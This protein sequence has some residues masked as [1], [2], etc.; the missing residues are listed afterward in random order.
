VLIGGSAGFNVAA[1]GTGVLTYQWQKNGLAIPVG[2]N[3]GFT[4][5]PV[6]MSDLGVYAVAVSNAYGGVLSAQASL[7]L[8]TTPTIQS[9]PQS[10]TNNAGTTAIFSVSASGNGLIYRWQRTGTNISDGGNLFGSATDT[11]A[12]T[13]VTRFDAT[14]YTVVITNAAGSVTS[15][16]AL[17]TVIFAYPFT[18]PFNYPVGSVLSNQVSPDFMTWTDV[19]TS[20]AG[21]VVTNGAG[22]LDVPGLAPS[23]GNSIRFGGAG[24]S[25][26]LSFLTGHAA[27]TGTIYFSFALNVLDLT[28]AAATTGGFIAGF[29]NSIGTQ[30]NQPSVIAPR[31]YIRT[32]GAGFNF[33]VAKNADNTTTWDT[34][35]YTINQTNFIVG[36]YTFNT[37][38]DT[39]D[40][41]CKMWINPAPASFGAASPPIPTV[42]ALTGSD[43]T[44]NSIASFVFFQRA[45]TPEPAVMIADELRI[46]TAWAGVT[47][48]PA[49]TILTGPAS[50]TNNPGTTATFTVNAD[51]SNLGYQ[52]V[53]NGVTLTNGGNI[54]GAT[55]STLTV[56]SVSQSDAG[57]YQVIVST[58]GGSVVSAAATLTVT[59]PPLV[60][61]QPQ[62]QTT[63]VGGSAVF[64]VT[65]SGTAPFG[66]QWRF[67]G[68]NISGATGSSYGL[69]NVQRTNGGNYSAVI[70]NGAGNTISS[71][72]LLT[73]TPVT[74]VRLSGVTLLS[75]G[76]L[77]LTVTG[78]PGQ[79]ILQGSSNLFNWVDLTNILAANGTFNYIDSTTNLSRYFYR[80]KLYP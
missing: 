30:G 9:Q 76:R 78:D 43:I 10:R 33:G 23:T 32:S 14:N 16:P 29:N 70:T 57:S 26:R 41:F 2:T 72:G 64:T 1:V 15:A 25:A 50:R 46:D 79:F 51:G 54:S 40:D 20:S 34:T 63:N 67:N 73:V 52:W 7:V 31:V 62:N 53:R 19:G 45:G 48:P 69:T 44:A 66:Y 61:A 65:A 59:A 74:P 35:V 58:G 24:K 38:G 71:N 13:A 47:P 5:N 75:G 36:S 4:I 56:S 17:L 39:T 11:L 18:E 77:Q 49:P 60:T 68:T 28:G 80:A 21:P 55:N 6:Q 12:V 37:V 3:S 22:N 8:A 42:T 27:T